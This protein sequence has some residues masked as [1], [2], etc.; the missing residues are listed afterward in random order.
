[1]IKLNDLRGTGRS[2]TD[3]VIQLSFEELRKATKNLSVIP[4]VTLNAWKL[5]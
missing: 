5:V 2:L 1:M 4:K 3:V